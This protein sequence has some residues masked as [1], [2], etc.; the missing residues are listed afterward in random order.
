M[1]SNNQ[2]LIW[3]P[4]LLIE[5]GESRLKKERELEKEIIDDAGEPNEAAAFYLQ[6]QSGDAIHS[7]LTDIFHILKNEACLM[8]FE[9]IAEFLCLDRMIKEGKTGKEMVNEWWRQSNEGPDYY[10]PPGA[11]PISIGQLIHNGDPKVPHDLVVWHFPSMSADGNRYEGGRVPLLV[12]DLTSPSYEL[13]HSSGS[14]PPQRIQAAYKLNYSTNKRKS[15]HFP[16]GV[17]KLQGSH[18]GKPCIIVGN[19]P[20]VGPQMELLKKVFADRGDLCVLGTNRAVEYFGPDALDY[21]MQLDYSSNEGWWKNVPRSK[22]EKVKAILWTVVGPW[23]HSVFAP[24]HTYWMH[25]QFHFP[26][27]DMDEQLAEAARIG[28]VGAGPNIAHWSL[29]FAYR[30]LEADPIILVGVDHAYTFGEC[31]VGEP[32]TRGMVEDPSFHSGLEFCYDL[33]DRITVTDGRLKRMNRV[34]NGLCSLI[35]QGGFPAGA[36]RSARVVNCSEH[37]LP[38]EWAEQSNLIDFLKKEVYGEDD[39]SRRFEAGLVTG[40]DETATEIQ[41]DDKKL[42]RL[43]I[44]R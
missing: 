42:S 32:V 12:S 24:K 1:C 25:D 21:Y 11:K 27:L 20:S 33:K 39:F 40:C 8:S 16:Q 6:T 15:D 10:K 5:V 30:I 9:K 36:R 37:G 29:S 31:H 26:W 7:V 2:H 19:G 43:R 34:L 3:L 41:R 4:C 23:V 13:L 14:T 17:K 28:V 22:R 35:K 18:R 38:L 44:A